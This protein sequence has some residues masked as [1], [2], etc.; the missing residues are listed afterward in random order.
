[1]YLKK[2][3]PGIDNSILIITDIAVPNIPENAPNIIYKVPISL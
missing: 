1:M 2:V 3:S